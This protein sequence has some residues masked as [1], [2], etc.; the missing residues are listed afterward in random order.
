MTGDAM[1]QTH[2]I[3]VLLGSTREGRRSVQVAR[4]VLDALG[5][6]GGVESGLIDLADFGLPILSERPQQTDRPPPG[7]E[8]F[9]TRIKAADGLVIVTP[10]YKGGIPGVLKNALDHLD[11]GIFGRKPIG[12]ATVSA[13]G[14][15]G[16][17]C[18]AQL[19]LVCLAMGGI[20]VPATFPVSEV[21]AAF[22]ERGTA[23][24]PRLVP[25]LGPF[26]DEL[27]WYVTAT[28]RQ[29][30]LDALAAPA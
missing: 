24:D 3:P 16:M 19:R 26:L 11:P 7:Y 21:D 28:T 9:R 15:G 17:N 20:P 18:L 1:A 6:R 4:F 29:R 22:D 27:T 13:G 23:V 10:E 14:F 30:R 5:L 25:R 8:P 2:N 12:I